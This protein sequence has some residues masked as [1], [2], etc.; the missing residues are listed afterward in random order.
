M[1]VYYK[2]IIYFLSKKINNAKIL[3]LRNRLQQTRNIAL[4]FLD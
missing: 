2:L 1:D 3:N 4:V